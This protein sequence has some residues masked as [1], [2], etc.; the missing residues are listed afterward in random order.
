[1]DDLIAFLRAR[2]D[3]DEQ[4]GLTL[5]GTAYNGVESTAGPDA[6]AYLERAAVE[7]EAK[8]RILAEHAPIG[9]D[10][11]VCALVD[12]EECYDGENEWLEDTFTRIPAPC[13]TLR[14]LAAPYTEHPDYREEWRP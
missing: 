7:V 10:C 2:L 5:D 9:P 8:R 12:R 14:A 11:Q 4:L 13:P 1:M 6:R 3:E